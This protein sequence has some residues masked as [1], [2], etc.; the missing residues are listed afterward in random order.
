MDVVILRGKMI[1]TKLSAHKTKALKH[2]LGNLEYEIYAKDYIAFLEFSLD[3]FLVYFESINSCICK[4]RTKNK[5]HSQECR[6]LKDVIKTYK[7]VK[8]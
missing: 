5:R 8:D 2:L 7:S 6:E 1:N 3:K 4:S